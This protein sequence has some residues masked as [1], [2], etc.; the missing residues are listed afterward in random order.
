M[1]DRDAILTHFHTLRADLLAAIDGLTPAQ[2]TEQPEGEWS[3]KDQLFHIAAWDRIRAVEVARISAGHTSSWRMSGEQD[4]A[5]NEMFYAL[6]CDLDIE[7]ALW[8]LTTSREHLLEAIARATERG[9][10]P[11]LYGEAGL[12][13]EHEALHATWIREWRAKEGY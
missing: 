5:L 9:L 2:L 7:Q 4:A 13:T 1:P 3:I 11:S 12:M 10:D 6:H 8:E